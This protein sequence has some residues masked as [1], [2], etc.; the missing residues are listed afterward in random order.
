VGEQEKPASNE[1]ENDRDPK[2][3]KEDMR[4]FAQEGLL[5]TAPTKRT[6]K[7]FFYRSTLEAVNKRAKRPKLGCKV[8]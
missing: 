4:G 7:G 2:T 8:N 5:H 3:G 6:T 1:I